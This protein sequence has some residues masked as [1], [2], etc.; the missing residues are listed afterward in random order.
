MYHVN[1]PHCVSVFALTMFLVSASACTD[2][3]TE[4][5]G[6]ISN[7]ERSV[8]MQSSRNDPGPERPDP[9]PWS[10]AGRASA[11]VPLAGYETSDRVLNERVAESDGVEYVGLTP[12]PARAAYEAGIVPAVTSKG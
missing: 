10:A 8:V 9:R 1:K 5:D 6:S 11:E 7:R 4:P 3:I 2:P 12:P